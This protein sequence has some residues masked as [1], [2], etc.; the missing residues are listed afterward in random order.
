MIDNKVK[1]ILEENN[2]WWQSKGVTPLVPKYERDTV[3]TLKK[4]SLQ[5]AIVLIGARQ[6]GKTTVMMQ[7]IKNLL[8][9]IDPTSIEYVSFDSINGASINDIVFAH[10]ELPG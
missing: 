2:L 5:K 1:R 9:R 6:S 4:A 8:K 3:D 7:T 10:Q